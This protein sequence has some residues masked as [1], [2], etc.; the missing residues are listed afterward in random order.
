[1]PYKIAKEKAG[2]MRSYLYQMNIDEIGP[3]DTYDEHNSNLTKY[4]LE[5]LCGK[6]FILP[7][8]IMNIIK[9]INYL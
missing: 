6:Y 4:S 2:L 8:N 1:M 7:K 3:F 5:I 9:N